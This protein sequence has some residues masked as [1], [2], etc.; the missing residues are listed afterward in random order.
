MAIE[1]FR[2]AADDPL[3][4]TRFLAY[5]NMGSAFH[6]K[7]N[8]KTAI[9]HYR[10]AIDFAPDYSSSYEKMGVSY[11]ALKDWNNALA[12]YKRASELSP[13]AALYHLRLGIAYL[14]VNRQV[15][16]AE[17]LLAAVNLDPQGRV[18]EEAKRILNDMRKRQ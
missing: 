1:A 10:K 14:Q 16:A 12:A 3:Y 15:E 2:K 8:Y 17:A 9:E 6:S 5:E 4:R 11:E 18:G 13:D 7:G